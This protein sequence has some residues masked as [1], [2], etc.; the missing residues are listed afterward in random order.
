[1]PLTLI[2]ENKIL[3][4][5]PYP[6]TH[7]ISSCP[8]SQTHTVFQLN[9]RKKEGVRRKWEEAERGRGTE[10][11]GVRGR[12][13]RGSTGGPCCRRR[14]EPSRSAS[15]YTKERE[16]EI[17]QE[18]GDRRRRECGRGSHRRQSPSQGSAASLPRLGVVEATPAAAATRREGDGSLHSRERESATGETIAAW[19]AV[20]GPP[21][22][23]QF[24][25]FCRRETRRCGGL[26]AAVLVAG[27]VTAEAT[28]VTAGGREIRAIAAVYAAGIALSLPEFLVAAVL[29]SLPWAVICYVVAA[30]GPAALH[31]RPP[32]VARVLLETPSELPLL[33]VVVLPLKTSGAEDLVVADF[34]LSEKSSVDTLGLWFQHVEVRDCDAWVV[35]VV[36][37]I[38][39]APG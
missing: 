14:A 16:K 12:E 18:L 17:G 11:G 38:P 1:M 34:G 13:G 26:T 37:V 4:L 10:S 31:F 20:A 29:V 27:V 22:R 7:C 9:E 24:C 33:G 36:V 2:F 5:K 8:S 30:G 23:R 25:L 39:L 21:C 35:A 3:T 15:L 28:C 6:V 32:V 19:V